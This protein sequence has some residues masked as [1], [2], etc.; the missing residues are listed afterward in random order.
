MLDGV[1]Q[2]ISGEIAERNK[3]NLATED[4]TQVDLR[5]KSLH[6]SLLLPAADSSFIYLIGAFLRIFRL[7]PVYDG[8]Q[9]DGGRISGIALRNPNHP[10]IAANIGSFVL[11]PVYA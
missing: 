10:I 9:N 1:I 2:L 7:F 4:S 8:S 5:S 11:I 6:P 3:R